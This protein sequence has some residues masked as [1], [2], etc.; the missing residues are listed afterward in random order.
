MA[1]KSKDSRIRLLEPLATEFAALRAAIGGGSTEIGAL[2]EAAAAYIK[3]RTKDR[4]FRAR[5]E[6]EL[7]KLLGSK[8][9]RFRVVKSGE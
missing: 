9:Q 1:P 7:K 6:E 3:L 5:Y 2:R 4:K 8:R